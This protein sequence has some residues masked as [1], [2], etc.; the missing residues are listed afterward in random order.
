[1]HHSLMRNNPSQPAQSNSSTHRRRSA[2]QTKSSDSEKILHKPEKSKRKRG[3]STKAA[4]KASNQEAKTTNAKENLEEL[5]PDNKPKPDN[6]QVQKEQNARKS[7]RL[8][9]ASA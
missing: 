7:I 2:K 6:K 4:V 9:Q 3:S 8:I 5:K 1:M